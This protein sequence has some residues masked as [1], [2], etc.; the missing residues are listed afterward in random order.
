[1]LVCYQTTSCFHRAGECRRGLAMRIILSVCLSVKRDCDKK[2]ERS[3]Q[4]FI[5][6]ER[7]FSIV[8]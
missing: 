6:Y 5:P 4:I 2:E 3:V 1:M 7:P 8:F